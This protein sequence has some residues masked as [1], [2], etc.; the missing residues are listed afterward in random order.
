MNLD[1]GVAVNTFPSNF[2]PE[3]VRDGSF[4]DWV[5]DGEAWQFQGCDENGL[6]RSLNGRFT[7]RSVV[8]HLHQH[9]HQE[10]RGSRAKN[11][12]TSM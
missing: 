8:Q 12:K 4:N 2:G 9:Q 11:N 10:L 5:P 1:I 3:G 7:A 6:P